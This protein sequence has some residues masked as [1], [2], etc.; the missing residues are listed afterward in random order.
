M[1]QDGPVTRRAA[2]WRGSAA[3]H[4]PILCH[5]AHPVHPV[6]AVWRGAM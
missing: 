2:A 4:P 3:V 1:E 5:P 6:R